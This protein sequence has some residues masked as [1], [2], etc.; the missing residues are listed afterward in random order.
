MREIPLDAEP[1]QSLR[2]LLGDQECSLNVYQRGP[3]LY[4]DLDV[5]GRRICTG[6]VCLDRAD[7]PVSP[8]A[9]FSGRLRF[10]DTRGREAPRWDG[11]GA[12]WTL[13]WLSEDEARSERPGD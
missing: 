2:V 9:H 10:A 12:R 8:T 7:M 11:L 4:L 1:S 5:D 3:R 13:L 6:A